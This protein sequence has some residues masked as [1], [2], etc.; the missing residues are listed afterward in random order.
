M[1]KNLAVLFVAVCWQLVFASC[2]KKKGFAAIDEEAFSNVFD[3]V[4]SAENLTRPP[5]PSSSGSVMACVRSSE[6]GRSLFLSDLLTKEQKTIPVTND[7]RRIAGWSPDGR[8]LVFEQKPPLSE[9]VLQKASGR[10]LAEDRNESWLTVFDS[11]NNT[12]WRLTMNSNVNER[13]FVWL[14]PNTFFYSSDSDNKELRGTYWGNIEDRT[15]K[16]VSAPLHEFVRMAETKAAYEKGKNIYAFEI[17]STPNVG[18]NWLKPRI[19]KVS[20]FKPDSF[21]SIRWLHFCPE[22][23]CFLFCA[24]PG[25]SPWRYLFKFNPKT[26]ELTQLSDQDTYN[27]QWLQQG[28]GFAYVGNTNNSFFLA[29]RP[30]NQNGHT[31]LFTRGSVANYVVADSGDQVFGTAALGNEPQGVWQYD[32]RN[33]TLREVVPGFTRQLSY[34]QWV[35]SQE[36]RAKSYD[37]LEIPY[38]LF[39]PMERTNGI[40]ASKIGKGSEWHG[41]RPAVIYLPPQTFQFQRGFSARSQMMANLGFYFI[42]VNYRGCDGYG[43]NYS[44][45]DDSHG[46][47]QDVL[48]VYE[49]V[50]KRYPIDEKNVFLFT[51]SSGSGAGWELLA[52][53]PERWRGAAL[54]SPA[55]WTE[56]ERYQPRKFPALLFT[57]GDQDAAGPSVEK[58]K[59]W[60][61]ANGISARFLIYT[62]S[63]HITYNANE[64][65]SI[66]EAVARFCLEHV[67]Q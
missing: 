7:V 32:L 25:D 35:E 49:E 26:H 28:R 66:H 17:K 21:D 48:A 13:W 8:Y 14:T 53:A 36:F 46:A 5:V 39:S 45:L 65:R 22:N 2:S 54:V 6:F 20:D 51:S 59:V 47:A 42:A 60:V 55:G 37:G 38:F 67:Q 50:M 44:K 4:M 64:L 33:N 24:R 29:L 12:T 40:A 41:K 52:V 62:N 19:E 58:L 23:G 16:Q 34:C 3:E 27:G 18:D 61:A 30:E 10:P 57:S 63:G 56:D 9:S 1:T 11:H 43:R 15:I 31:N